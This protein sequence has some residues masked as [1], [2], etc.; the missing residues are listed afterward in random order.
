MIRILLFEVVWVFRMIKWRPMKEMNE[1][2]SQQKALGILLDHVS[3]SF[4][5]F[6]LHLT[7]DENWNFLL[8]FCTVNCFGLIP[9]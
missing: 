3:G 8:G 7:L 6:Q 1:E 4:N 5:H 2:G 9:N